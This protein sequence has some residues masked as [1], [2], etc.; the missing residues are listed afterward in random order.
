MKLK[1][2]PQALIAAIQNNMCLCLVGASG[3]GKS[4]VTNDT[5]IE[6]GYLMVDM[7]LSYRDL[8]DVHGLP[9]IVTGSDGQRSVEWIPP[10]EFLAADKPKGF[11]WDEITHATSSVQS[12]AYQVLTENRVGGHPLPDDCIHVAAHNR[13]TDKGIHN[14][15]PNPLRR[16]WC[17]VEVTADVD[18]W[19]AW[20]FT[21]GIDPVTIACIKNNPDMLYRDMTN[22]TKAPDP[23][24][25]VK[26]DRLTAN[27]TL[28]TDVWYEM[29]SG[30]VGAGD[31][32]QYKAY[33]E[34]YR[35]LPSID[36]IRANPKTAMIPGRTE[37]G[38]LHAVTCA[39]ARHMNAGTADAF[40]TYLKRLPP[41]YVVFSMKDA[42]QANPG[43]KQTKTYV[44]FSVEYQHIV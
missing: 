29:V 38:L 5:L 1:D 33:L 34:L 24:A 39:I 30:L 25:W 2:V 36:E 31:A 42:T 21:H 32:I 18:S 28:N 8:V 23:R 37:T 22:D 19:V 44:N 12:L 10:V 35:R 11:F 9:C 14:R 43:I 40:F 4:E 27:N 17:E 20:A 16:R 15:V 41:E 6:L 13:V 7:R 3:I 26:V